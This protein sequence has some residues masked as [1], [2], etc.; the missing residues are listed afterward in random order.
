MLSALIVIVLL[1]GALTS[2]KRN[3]KYDGY[4][5]IV[6]MAFVNMIMMIMLLACCK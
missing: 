1:L 4:S 6:N 5:F 3:V 2:A